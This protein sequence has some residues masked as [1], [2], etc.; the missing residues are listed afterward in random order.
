MKKILLLVF[1][2]FLGVSLF[3]QKSAVIKLN[4]EKNKVYRMKM[5]SEQT[6]AQTVN[7][8]QQNVLTNVS[9][10]VSLKMLDMTKDFMVTEVHFDTLITNTNTMGKITAITSAVDGDIKSS[11]L[12]EIMSC[13]MSRLSKNAVYVK[14]DF[15]GKPVEIINQKLLSDI[16]L[17]D[18]SSI[19]LTGPTGAA[20]KKQVAATVGDDNLKRMIEMFTWSLPAREV[21]KGDK[22]EMNQQTNS[23]GMFLDIKTT[24]RL[25]EINGDM[26]KISAESKISAPPDAAP[27]QSPGAT[28]TYDNLQGLSKSNMLIDIQTGLPVSNEAKTH[29]SRN[30]GVS[31]PGFSMEIPMDINGE[32]KVFTLK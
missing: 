13:I 27:I 21:S 6:I 23:G 28:V 22:W 20:V 8:I 24:C 3:A 19:S 7:G 11:E 25:D 16:V 12:G 5:V 17:K 31:G 30:L 4:L 29:I 15:S 1:S 14:L 32:S 9:Y 18:T 10:T 26:A 2:F